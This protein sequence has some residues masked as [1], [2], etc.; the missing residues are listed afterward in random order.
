MPTNAVWDINKLNNVGHTI[1]PKR[2]QIPP[3]YCPE[4]SRLSSAK[5]PEGTQEFLGLVNF[6][7]E[8]IAKM[9]SVADPLYKLTRRGES[10]IWGRAAFD[11]LKHILTNSPVLLGYPEWDRPFYLQ[12][13]ASHVAVGG[14]LSQ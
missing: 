10:F 3:E 5:G 14:V 8:Y 9:A 1:T 2:A 11:T 6:Y 12:A 4:G 13:D 7:R